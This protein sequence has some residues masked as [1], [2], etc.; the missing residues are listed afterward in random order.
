MQLVHDLQQVPTLEMVSTNTDAV[1]FTIEE[2]YREQAHK[3]LHNWE[4]LTG[5]EL[6]EDKIVKIV[7]RD[8]NNYC[9]IVQT[10]DNDFKVNYKGG[11]FRGN[12]KF[13]WDKENKI[14]NYSFDD[15]IENNSLTIVSE[16]ILK[17]LLF[18]IPVEETINNCNDIFRFQKITHL[19]NTYDRIVQE[20]PNG[21]AVLQKNNRIYAGKKPSGIL[22]KIK[23]DGRRDSLADCPINPIVDN[24]NN[25]TI[26]DINKEWYIEIAKQRVNDFRGVKRL[27]DYKK[28]E[29]LE[30]ATSMGLDVDK[31]IK[32]AELLELVK[33]K[34]KKKE[35]ENMSKTVNNPSTST[36]DLHAM[37]IG[38]KIN[39]MKKDIKNMEFV[40]DC[41]QATNLGGKEYPSIGQY[42]R[43]I[44]DLSIK[45]NLL[46][47]WEVNDVTNTEKEMFKP[48][49]KMPQ[50]VTTVWCKATF[51]DLDSYDKE[52]SEYETI[53]YN[54]YAS[55]SDT[56]DKGVSAASSMAFRNWFDKNFAPSYLTS[57][58]FGE[59]NEVNESSRTVEPKIPTYIPPEKKEELIE[60]VVNTPQEEPENS[61]DVKNV[62]ANIMKVRE[63][64]G[65][66]EWGAP[67]LQR[68]MNNEIDSVS[69]LEIEL[70]VN[71]KLESLE[72]DK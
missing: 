4:E 70:K 14:F 33:Q 46:F 11:E 56:C 44:N 26:D 25:C 34:Q 38:Q 40:M 16:A 71:A 15:S 3:V 55:G 2:S 17:H 19:G 18:D 65:N 10:G 36:S 39:E 29:L 9:E 24:G 31:K 43:V 20:T 42:Y 61:D 23:P 27:E 37:T 57:D 47:K 66:Q 35:E 58:E 1:M 52:T 51:D 63:L 59:T 21:D 7:M 28:D 48:Q 72:G 30:I 49:G 62:I 12:H 32:K 5:L 45:Y 13:K 6:E 53:Y 68:L 67:T 50:H 41:V 8:V 64:L 60:K 54:V 22:V 69:L